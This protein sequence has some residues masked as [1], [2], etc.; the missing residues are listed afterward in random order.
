MWPFHLPPALS[1]NIHAKA[2]KRESDG[3]ICLAK[4]KIAGNAAM[5]KRANRLRQRSFAAPQGIAH[6]GG[7]NRGQGKK[8]RPGREWLPVS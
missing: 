3:G 6:F 7:E 4:G 2:R 1:R 8:R 5:G